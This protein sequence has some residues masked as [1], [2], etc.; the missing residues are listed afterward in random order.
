MSKDKIKGLK[1]Y[2]HEWE[3]D[4]LE[5]IPGTEEM[6]AASWYG[7]DYKPIKV[8]FVVKKVEE[9]IKIGGTDVLFIHIPG[10]TPGSIALIVEDDEKKILFGQDIHGPFE[11]QFRS[12]KKDWANSMKLLISKNCDILCEGHYGIYKSP[13]KVLK[14]IRG[15]LRQNN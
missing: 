6:T 15:Q 3:Q 2:A 11:K 9:M 10:H 5:G 14:F 7:V 4:V 8:D 1:I 13:D 12:N